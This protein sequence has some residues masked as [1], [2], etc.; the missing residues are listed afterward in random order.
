M[1]VVAPLVT[2]PRNANTLLCRSPPAFTL[3]SPAPPSG[4]VFAHR[5]LCHDAMADSD[6][7]AAS[8]LACSEAPA[9]R[10][11]FLLRNW[12]RLTYQ[13]MHFRGDHAWSA[14]SMALWFLRLALALTLPS[15]M[16]SRVA[17]PVLTYATRASPLLQLLLSGPTRRPADSFLNFF[18]KVHPFGD[19]FLAVTVP[20]T[21]S[22]AEFAFNLMSLAVIGLAASWHQSVPGGSF[23]VR[24]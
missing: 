8:A 10:V 9:A 7:H 23:E 6:L 17:A 21:Y 14:A 15:R 1:P 13:L 5:T 2:C 18:Y 11:A 16:Y 19:A 4:V 24:A 12:P 20:T 3:P 22:W